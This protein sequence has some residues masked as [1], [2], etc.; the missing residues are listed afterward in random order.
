MAMYSENKWM[1]G[2][3]HFSSILEFLFSIAVITMIYVKI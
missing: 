1:L 2:K 3:T